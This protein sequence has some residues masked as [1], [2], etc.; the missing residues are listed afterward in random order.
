MT[1]RGIDDVRAEIDAVDRDI[2]RLIAQRQRSVV[3]AGLMKVDR[4]A[5][6]APGRVEQVVD[7]VRTLADEAGA[8]PEVVERTYR[9]MIGAFIDLELSVHERR[10][11]SRG[12]E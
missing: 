12:D 10:A 9:A 11:P 7:K 8:D 6:R 4:H 5:V 3:E 2:V 1:D